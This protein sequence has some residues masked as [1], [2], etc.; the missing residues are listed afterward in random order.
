MALYA[1]IGP[2]L[3]HYDLDVESASLVKRD[4]VTL[5]ESVQY[6]WP[7]P[8]R[9]F[10]YVAWSNGAGSNH[11][12]VTAFRIDPASGALRPHGAPIALAARSVHITVD[13]PG[14]HLL[15]AYNDPSG[16]TVHRL[17]SDGTIGSVVKQPAPLDVGI[18]GHQ[19]RVDPSNQTVILVTRGNGP[20]KGKPEDPGALK[21]FSYRD[22][23]LTNRASIAPNGG[24]GFQPRHLD[25]D[26][27]GSWV[28]VSLERQNKL[29]VY[30]RLVDGML[31]GA[32]LFTKDSVT[33]PGAARQGQAAGTVHVHPA[34]GIVYQANRA[35]G[36]TMFEGKRVS[37]GGE[38][39]IAVY[40]VNPKTGEPSLIQ[41]ADTHGIEPRTFALDGGGR[42]LVAANQNAA[43][44]REGQRLSTVPASLAVFRIRAGGKLDYARKYD[45]ET[46]GVG[47]LFWM[48]IVSPN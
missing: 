24:F 15:V 29:Q 42:V 46:E 7:H 41:N 1:A 4:S 16:L 2:S 25:F 8:S 19:V 38:N 30:Q 21:I 45:V 17:A 37:A 3:V 10:I 5:P 32:P 12:G 9:Q 44:A 14:T 40:A 48:G 28:F 33:E 27:S 18:Y 34:G 36:T 23:I 20:A 31:G 47:S 43:L 39:A 11:H 6:A 13:I 26:K 35:S 22:G